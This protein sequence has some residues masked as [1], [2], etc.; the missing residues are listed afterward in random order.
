VTVVERRAG[1]DRRSRADKRV[2]RRPRDSGVPCSAAVRTIGV[3]IRARAIVTGHGCPVNATISAHV[4]L[5]RVAGRCRAVP[6]AARAQ[7]PLCTDAQPT[8]ARDHPR[9]QPAPYPFDSPND[10]QRR[11]APEISDGARRQR[12]VKQTRLATHLRPA[13]RRMLGARSCSYRTFCIR[14]APVGQPFAESTF[15]ARPIPATDMSRERAIEAVPVAD[16][17]AQRHERGVSVY[18]WLRGYARCLVR[19]R[20]SSATH[21]DPTVVPPRR[22]LVDRQ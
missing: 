21:E 7:P 8:S 13:R 22:S 9:R 15:P 17:W 5:S 14:S 11:A 10:P 18:R 6:C 12:Q 2:G 20:A 4:I 16:C 1:P 19:P 3:V